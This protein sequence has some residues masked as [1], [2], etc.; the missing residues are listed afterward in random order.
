MLKTCFFRGDG[1]YRQQS[2]AQ[3]YRVGI[4]DELHTLLEYPDY[5][6]RLA[7]T[8][9]IELPRIRF[10]AK[11]TFSTLLDKRII[12]KDRFNRSWS[13]YG[14]DIN[15]LVPAMAQGVVE[16]WWSIVKRGAMY[17]L[18]ADLN[19]PIGPVAHDRDVPLMLDSVSDLRVLETDFRAM[20]V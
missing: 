7:P 19:T 17:G 10:Q 4:A 2:V 9:V 3:Q 11:M 6:Q 12:M 13:V 18:N 14:S 15:I 16:C 5:I 1:P 8:E 20:A